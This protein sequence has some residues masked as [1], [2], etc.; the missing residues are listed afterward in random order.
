[1][2]MHL[3]RLT[4]RSNIVAT[5]IIVAT[6]GAVVLAELKAEN[7][8]W[9]AT[10]SSDKAFL[11]TTWGMSPNEVERATRTPLTSADEFTEFFAQ[12]VQLV[13]P[14]RIR[15]SEQK[16]VHKLWGHFTNVDF[17]FFDNMLCEYYIGLTVYNA[18]TSIDEIRTSLV[19]RFGEAT[20]SKRNSED[21]IESLEWDNDKQHTSFW[22]IRQD[23]GKSYHVGIRAKYLPI[24]EKISKTIGKEKKKYF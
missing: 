17:T 13:N 10:G 7:Y 14:T 21:T 12:E 22:A 11:D 2:R 19:E 15:V 5:I 18:D 24:Q 20:Q 6:A 16:N 8:L 4:I 1:M 3:K 23:N 9:W